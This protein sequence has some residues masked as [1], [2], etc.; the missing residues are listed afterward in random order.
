MIERTSRHPIAA[1]LMVAIAVAMVVAGCS[2]EPRPAPTATPDIPA[3][4]SAAVA[5]ALG[6]PIATPAELT[7]A[8]AVRSP[9]V[10]PAAPQSEVRQGYC[11][12]LCDGDDWWRTAK[13]S[14]VQAELD[15][16]ADVTAADANGVTPLH[17]AALYGYVGVSGLL[18]DS[19]ANPNA[20]DDHGYAPLYYALIRSQP[21]AKVIVRDRIA[22]YIPSPDVVALLLHNG[23]DV[24]GNVSESY[25]GDRSY[26]LLALT[27][28]DPVSTEVVKILVDHGANVN[29]SDNQG[30]TLLHTAA[31]TSPSIIS[32]LLENGGQITA[33][34]SMGNTPLHY[35]AAG[36]DPAT[37][38]LLLNKGADRNARNANGQTACNTAHQNHSYCQYSNYQ[39]LSYC[40]VGDYVRTRVRQILCK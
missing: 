18:L 27:H 36:D 32:L 28:G 12:R 25:P 10:A 37:I 2:S 17:I 4:V 31:T 23:A 6:T 3:T 40:E 13:L 22:G 16:G 26:L 1:L 14:D 7:V 30:R 39:H 8:T 24:K 35:S 33:T 34:D 21:E 19:G 5:Q 11:G 29:V 15:L 9:A 20:R 38:L